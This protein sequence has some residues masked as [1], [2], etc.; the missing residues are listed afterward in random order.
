DL[1]AVRV[2]DHRHTVRAG[3]LDRV[4]PHLGARLAEVH[5]RPGAVDHVARHR[6]ATHAVDQRHAVA[7]GAADGVPGEGDPFSRAVHHDAR[8][9]AVDLVVVQADVEATEQLD[10]VGAVAGGDAVADGVV[11]VAPERGAHR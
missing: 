6:R 10:P 1:A 7:F 3:A 4:A 9:V 5:A 11:A 2:A 8:G